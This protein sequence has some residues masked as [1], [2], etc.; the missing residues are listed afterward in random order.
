MAESKA[1][2]PCLPATCKKP[3]PVVNYTAAGR[4]PAFATM[5]T[6][7]KISFA[8]DILISIMFLYAWLKMIFAWGDNGTI[9][10]SGLR[11]LKYFT[12]LSNLLMGAASAL[13]VV[14]TI[15]KLKHNTDIP[16]WITKL[17]LA[18]A[19]AV[20]LTFLVVLL[21]LWPVLKI[22]GLYSGATLWLHLLVP[23]MAIASFVL[24]ARVPISLKE[25]IVSV[26]PMLIY[27]AW[28]IGNNLI[29]GTGEWPDT[30]DWYGFLT[31]G[32]KDG[33]LIFAVLIIMTWGAGLIMRFAHNK[34]YYG[35]KNGR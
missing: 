23:L 25:S 19:T 17:R 28:Y 21:F 26:I 12:I 11:N 34:V 27:G 35:D 9:S 8:L 3:L 13:T 31:W 6:R 30:N 10:A 18:G 24:G 32:W 14:Y 5:K 2:F 16:A 15:R 4:V 1:M 33:V 20:T 22:P 29:N 7:E